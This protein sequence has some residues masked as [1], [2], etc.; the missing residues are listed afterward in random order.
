MSAR[1]AALLAVALL[2]A[3]PA[4]AV[5]P[6][7][8][9][10]IIAEVRA[11]GCG[12]D[13]EAA[14]RVFDPLGIGRDAT[15]E[16]VEVL[17]AA[18]LASVSADGTVLTLSAGLCAADPTRDAAAYAAAA[19]AVAS[20]AEA[21]DSG[22]AAR[23]IAA[24]RDH[25]CA[26]T[27]AEAGTLLAALGF[28]AGETIGYVEVLVGAGLATLSEDFERFALGEGLCAADPATDAATYAA[29]L[30]AHAAAAPAAGPIGDDEL[31]AAVRDE[32]GP[33]AVAEMAAFEATMNG[34]ALDFADP[35]ALAARLAALMA[36]HV[37]MV[38]AVEPPLPAAVTAELAAAAATFVAAPGPDFAI[39]AGRLV[40]ID[41]TP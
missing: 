38:F 15:A 20:L 18:G 13:E 25:G 36:D 21:E 22:R 9:A 4:A 17:E 5:T 10:R 16:V 6:E 7:V 19:A 1:L 39:E 14:D 29:A 31:L 41:C 28:T 30:A 34:C 33:A 3:A 26:M 12:M 37:A 8:A 2:A 35:Q 23:F 32:F 11:A 27:E 40:L 24:I